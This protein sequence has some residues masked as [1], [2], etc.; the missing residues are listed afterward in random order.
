MWTGFGLCLHILLGFIVA[1]LSHCPLMVCHLTAGRKAWWESCGDRQGP[2]SV[3]GEWQCHRSSHLSD[4]VSL[5]ATE[6][7]NGYCAICYLVSFTAVYLLHSKLTVVIKSCYASLQ[8]SHV[9]CSTIFAFLS[10][11]VFRHCHTPGYIISL[12][13]QVSFSPLAGKGNDYWPEC[14]DAL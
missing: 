10:S 12:S 4:G 3:A 9:T 5:T 14:S 7:S 11:S 6:I 1:A 2:D 8:H 13:C